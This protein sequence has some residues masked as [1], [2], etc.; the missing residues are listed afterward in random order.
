MSRFKF[1]K[2]QNMACTFCVRRWAYSFHSILF[3]IVLSLCVQVSLGLHPRLICLSST[4]PSRISVMA[5]RSQSCHTVTESWVDGII[6]AFQQ[7]LHLT[8]RPDDVWLA[9]LTQF[10]FYV[11]NIEEPF[12]QASRLRTA[13]RPGHVEAF[14]Q[15]ERW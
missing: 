12:R 9:I 13:G 10:S 15:V 1:K 14:R 5:T 3:R 6:R 2:L 4:R 8:I 7:D 11:N